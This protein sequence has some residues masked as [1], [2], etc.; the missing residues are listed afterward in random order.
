MAKAITTLELVLKPTK[1]EAETLQ[2]IMAIG[3]V[4]N[5]AGKRYVKAQREAAN[6][7]LLKPLTR[8]EKEDVAKQVEAIAN[9]TEGFHDRLACL[10]PSFA[11]R[12]EFAFRVACMRREPR[13]LCDA[14]TLDVVT[15]D[16]MVVKQGKKSIKVTLP[17]MDSPVK[18]LRFTG[19]LDDADD[20]PE[21][22]ER[23]IVLRHKGG[24]WL[25]TV[26]EKSWGI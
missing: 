20:L 7:P 16:S 4:I 19:V 2:S 18:V 3:C 25:V 13:C 21:G 11:G 23:N 8:H 15:F 1:E 14:R 22:V 26:F 5:N 12:V 17:F 24:A 9:T 10:L 6:K